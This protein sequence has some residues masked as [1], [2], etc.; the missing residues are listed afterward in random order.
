METIDGGAGDDYLEGGKNHD[1]ITGG[2]G[3]DIIFGDETDS[4]CNS[5]FPESCVRYGN[6]VIQAR[7]GEVD[8]V[9]CGPGSDRVV[10]DGG[11]VVAANC[12]TVERGAAGPGSVVVDKGPEK[13]KANTSKPAARRFAFVGRPRLKTALR[14]GLKLRLTGARAGKATILVRQGRRKVASGRVTVPKG[15]TATVRVRFTKAAVRRLRSA[16]SVRLTVSG[17]G[18]R[19]TLTVRR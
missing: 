19:T 4:S 1:T 17:A 13:G 15:G 11:D 5:D 8:Q 9:D 6:D 10:A 16:R 14:A 18:V 12:E 2:P 3:K 7:D